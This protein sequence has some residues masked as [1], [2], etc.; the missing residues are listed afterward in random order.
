MI[1]Y[2]LVGVTND[3][4]DDWQINI[5]IVTVHC[6]V[7]SAAVDGGKL[8]G[9]FN[10]PWFEWGSVEVNLRDTAKYNTLVRVTS[11]FDRLATAIVKLF[12][13]YN[14]RSYM[15][16]ILTARYSDVIVDGINDNFVILSN[17]NS[18]ASRQRA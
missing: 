17:T 10:L 13:H 11:P 4:D 16:I 6:V 3:D 12:V 7:V 5:L 15:F 14:V 2:C 9:Y 18:T 8:V 1:L